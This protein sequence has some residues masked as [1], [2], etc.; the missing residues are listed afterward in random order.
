M[1]NE[2]KDLEAL[3]HEEAV[4]SLAVSSA[5]ERVQIAETEY[6]LAKDALDHARSVTLRWISAN[7]RQRA[8]ALK[9]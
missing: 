9:S 8:A 5:D 4:A 3:L 2:M 1:T 7:V 6:Q